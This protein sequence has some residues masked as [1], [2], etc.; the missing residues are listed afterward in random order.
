MTNRVYFIETVGAKGD[1]LF[2][3]QVWVTTQPRNWNSGCPSAMLQHGDIFM[4][5]L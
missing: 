5:S 4:K 2:L 3:S 1:S